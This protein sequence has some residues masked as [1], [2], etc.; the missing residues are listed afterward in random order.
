MR[1]L[2]NKPSELELD[3]PYIFAIS[4]SESNNI[5][6]HPENINKFHC[7]KVGYQLFKN[8]PITHNCLVNDNESVI[9][10]GTLKLNSRNTLE[11]SN[12][13]GHYKPSFE[14]L[15][16]AECLLKGKGFENIIK[17]PFIPPTPKPLFTLK[18]PAFL[19]LSNASSHI[20]GKTPSPLS[21][22]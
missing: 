15:D 19:N 3:K 1:H 16:Y 18:L 10:A 12:N 2:L 7:N 14:S 17:I 8:T 9:S 6:I 13:S 22:N 5:Y 4:V 20:E 11:I 21:L